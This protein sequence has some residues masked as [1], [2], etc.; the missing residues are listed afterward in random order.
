MVR[1]L[2]LYLIICCKHHNCWSFVA[3]I[4]IVNHVSH[5][6]KLLFFSYTIVAGLG[7]VE[8]NIDFHNASPSFRSRSS[9]YCKGV[10]DFLKM[11]NM[12]KTFAISRLFQI[13]SES[14]FS[15]IN[16]QGL[17]SRLLLPRNQPHITPDLQQ[18]SVLT[19]VSPPPDAL[20]ATQKITTQLPGLPLIST[21]LSPFNGLNFSTE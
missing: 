3:H 18:R 19:D 16:S 14:L 21:P 10:V 20:Y 12:S 9:W 13:F 2:C 4:S 17:S 5:T 1:V 7:N 8:E 6:S 15:N 11:A